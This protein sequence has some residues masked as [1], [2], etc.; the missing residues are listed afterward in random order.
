MMIRLQN[1]L[2]SQNVWQPCHHY[3][4]FIFIS[5][6]RLQPLNLISYLFHPILVASSWQL[7]F[8]HQGVW[9]LRYNHSLLSEAI[10]S[11]QLSFNATDINYNATQTV[12]LVCLAE[13][14]A[15]FLGTYLAYFYGTQQGGHIQPSISFIYIYI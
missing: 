7:L 6:R 9:G 1:V 10:V 15:A 4:K 8:L 11:T 3:Q 14:K 12:L 2:F 13:I 5:S